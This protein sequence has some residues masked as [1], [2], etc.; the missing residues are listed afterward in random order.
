LDNE[1]NYNQEVNMKGGVTKE[2]YDHLKKKLDEEEKQGF[3]WNG[4]EF[5]KTWA[6]EIDIHYSIIKA[7]LDEDTRLGLIKPICE[8][9]K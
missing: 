3:S 9:Y 6:Y 7:Q 5:C 2:E 1:K 8:K 4:L